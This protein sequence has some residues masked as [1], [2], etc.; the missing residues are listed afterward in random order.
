[1]CQVLCFGKVQ[2]GTS[3]SLHLEGFAVKHGRHIQ[4]HR[5]LLII[6]SLISWE[7][8]KKR[9]NPS[10]SLLLI[11]QGNE[12]NLETTRMRREKQIAAKHTAQDSATS[13]SLKVMT[14]TS[15]HL[16]HK[17]WILLVY[18]SFF[19]CAL[20]SGEWFAASTMQ[21]PPVRNLY[22]FKYE[23]AKLW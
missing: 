1:M 14:S 9:S 3:H 23:S 13:T 2:T 12:E 8:R 10:F 6:G 4:H 5:M 18:F 11:P 16:R 21:N 15:S 22:I 17:H 7:P 19:S 20:L